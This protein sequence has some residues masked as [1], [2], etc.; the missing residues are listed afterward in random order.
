MLFYTWRIILKLQLFENK[1]L[2]KIF[3][4]KRDE[5][6]VQFVIIHNEEDLYSLSSIVKMVEL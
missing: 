6:C 3:G 5:V 2:R 1:V 4:P